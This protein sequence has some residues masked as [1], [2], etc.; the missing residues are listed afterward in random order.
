ML[1]K[2]V[3][4]LNETGTSCATSACDDRLKPYR[5]GGLLTR[6]GRRRERAVSVGVADTVAEGGLSCASSISQ[7]LS[8]SLSMTV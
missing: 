2:E 3:A 1:S 7:S 5:T 8:P 6:E 4:D